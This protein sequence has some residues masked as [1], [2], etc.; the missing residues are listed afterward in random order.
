M[1]GHKK[2]TSRE[3]G[4]NV[5][6]MTAPRRAIQKVF[7]YLALHPLTGWD[8][9]NHLLRHLRFAEETKAQRGQKPEDPQWVHD[10][11]QLK[12]MVF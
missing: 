12:L 6:N 3:S 1:S 7:Q 5:A 11:K 8:A 9:R 2:N 4:H 10:G